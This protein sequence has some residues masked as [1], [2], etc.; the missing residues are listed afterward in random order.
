MEIPD[1]PPG[2]IMPA[3]E[4]P[5][6][7]VKIPQAVPR[8]HDHI[9]QPVAGNGLG[10]QRKRP[11]VLPAISHQHHGALHRGMSRCMHRHRRR[12]TAQQ[13]QAGE[14]VT[15]RPP[16]LFCFPGRL[17]D[18]RRVHP[19]TRQLHKI[20]PIQPPEI[21][22]PVQ[23]IGNHLPAFRQLGGGQSQLRRKYIHGAGRQHPE[24]RAVPS[25]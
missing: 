14:E 17:P 20:S 23:P 6:H 3:H 15:Q 16:P 25:P 12:G 19:H 7:G 11:S 4:R 22:F 9:Q 13:F 21:H 24:H 18:D 5:A 1:A 2:R 10:K 8:H